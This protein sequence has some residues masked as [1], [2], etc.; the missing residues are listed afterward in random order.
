MYLSSSLGAGRWKGR[1]W[2]AGAFVV[3]MHAWL[4]TEPGYQ[5]EARAH[6][7]H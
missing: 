5:E 1:G 4:K 6:H 7:Q 2:F 3:N